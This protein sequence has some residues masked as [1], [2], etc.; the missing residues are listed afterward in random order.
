VERSIWAV[1]IATF[2]LRLATGLT[3][4][5]L[6]FFLADLPAHGGPEV[7]PLVI[8]VFTALFFAA[9]LILS[10]PFGL[11]SDKLGHHRV[12]QIGPV[13]GLVAVI[14]TAVTAEIHLPGSIVIAI[15]VLVECAGLRRGAGDLPLGGRG[16]R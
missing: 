12:M 13:F 9:E 14:L 5:L 1:T 3:G 2:V 4:A 6:I 11:L 8:G 16:P 15:P 7:G 10:P